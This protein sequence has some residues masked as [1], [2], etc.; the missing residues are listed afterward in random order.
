MLSHFVSDIIDLK[1]KNP[2][3]IRDKQTF[4]LFIHVKSESSSHLQQT[5]DKHADF[6]LLVPADAQMSHF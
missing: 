1:G 2:A 4:D 5:Q 6:K 3:E